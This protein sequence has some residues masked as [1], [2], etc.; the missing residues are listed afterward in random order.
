[1]GVSSNLVF[2]IVL[3]KQLF[4]FSPGGI[5]KVD[6]CYLG[7]V[8]LKFVCVCVCVCVYMSCDGKAGFPGADCKSFVLGVKGRKQL[9]G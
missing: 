1:M 8:I 9:S 5:K 4:F 2:I 7:L 6:F 3:R